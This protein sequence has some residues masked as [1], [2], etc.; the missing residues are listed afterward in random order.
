M[1][2]VLK[3]TTTAAA[4]DA[5]RIILAH[6][7]LKVISHPGR[8]WPNA[9]PT[10]RVLERLDAAKNVVILLRQSLRSG[11]RKP[12]AQAYDF[13]GASVRRSREGAERRPGIHKFSP[14]LEQI[15]API[16]RFDPS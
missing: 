1:A 15:A 8:G 10:L 7:L 12:A 11:A 2:S 3:P 16:R 5:A 14:F 9:G 4:A 13:S 6:P